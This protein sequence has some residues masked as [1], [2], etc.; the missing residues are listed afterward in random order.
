MICI[1]YTLV[2]YE[3]RVN[4]ISVIPLHK[5]FLKKKKMYTPPQ[6]WYR[7]YNIQICLTYIK[8]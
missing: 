7:T 3:D 1:L 5:L 8:S 4:L 2:M 6:L